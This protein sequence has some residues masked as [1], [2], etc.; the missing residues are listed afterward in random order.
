MWIWLL[1]AFWCQFG[2]VCVFAKDLEAVL[3]S[4]CCGKVYI[5][6]LDDNPITCRDNLMYSVSRNV[7]SYLLE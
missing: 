3:V 5:G 4:Y 7:F 6:T 1:D 2:H